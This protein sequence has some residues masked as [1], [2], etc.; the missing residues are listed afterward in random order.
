MALPAVEGYQITSAT[1][2]TPDGRTVVGTAISY[3]AR[4]IAFSWN[5]GQF[6]HIDQRPGSSTGASKIS[7]DGSTI[8]GRDG[9]G[10]TER[11]SAV[12]W[13]NGGAA[14]Y[15][16]GQSA[17]DQSIAVAVSVDGST[18][19]G[20]TWTDDEFYSPFIYREE[21]GV[22]YLPLPEGRSGEP[23]G[24]SQDG[25]KV[26]GLLGSGN[27]LYTWDRDHG[28]RL[29][30][31]FST[32][33]GLTP[34][35]RFVYGGN[36][37]T[38]LGRDK[39]ARWSED[40]GVDYLPMLP[41]DT[42]GYVSA[43]NYDG[44]ML[45][46]ISYSG[47]SPQ[48]AFFWSAATGTVELSSWLSSRGANLDGFWLNRPAAMSWDGTVIVGNGTYLGKSRPWLATVPE[49]STVLAL[50]LPTIYLCAR[51]RSLRPPG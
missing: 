30:T 39:P 19:A 5:N 45:A 48:R 10:F 3:H 28:T 26:F 50:A 46:G 35:S 12:L 1:S 14:Q 51:R 36:A 34:D 9:G 2:M 6:R 29:H 40:G 32:P 13:R 38:L 16:E 41:G 20:Y 37:A 49:P 18:V 27:A 25:S 24:L 4:D 23:V 33:I 42:S 44:S 21:T 7:G 8:V 47:V 31:T 22:E 17:A 11:T 15:L 43:S